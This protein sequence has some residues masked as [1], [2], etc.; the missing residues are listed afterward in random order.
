MHPQFGLYASAV[1]EVF[2][3][4]DG[5]PICWRYVLLKPN[6]LRMYVRN[7][8]SPPQPASEASECERLLF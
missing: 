5:H 3:R 8:N 1:G 7:F 6:T 4:R 2:R